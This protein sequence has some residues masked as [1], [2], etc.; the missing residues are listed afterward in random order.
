MK[1]GQRRVSAMFD[2]IANEIETNDAIV[3]VNNIR[4]L[5]RSLGIDKIKR[6]LAGVLKRL[7]VYNIVK[8]RTRDEDYIIG[9]DPFDHKY[10]TECTYGPFNE[11]AEIDRIE[12]RLGEK[13]FEWQSESPLKQAR[14][15]K[16]VSEE[17]TTFR[18]TEPIN[19]ISSFDE[20]GNFTR[21]T[22]VGR[23]AECQEELDEYCENGDEVSA[24]VL[25]ILQEGIRRA[26]T[27]N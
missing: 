5:G 11:Q 10:W 9:S 21:G 26:A 23:E 22:K 16:E 7:T 14:F 25:K 6:P 19:T 12:E 3:R 15:T 4:E 8:S 1:I 24:T 18:W 17:G 2:H 20:D 13:G 27:G